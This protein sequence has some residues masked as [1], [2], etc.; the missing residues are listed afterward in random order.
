MHCSPVSLQ[1]LPDGAA[2]VGEIQLSLISNVKY[3]A[4]FMIHPYICGASVRSSWPLTAIASGRMPLAQV[5]FIQ[6]F[7]DEVFIV[8]SILP[9]IFSLC[10]CRPGTHPSKDPRS[11][12]VLVSRVWNPAFLSVP[13]PLHSNTGHVQC[14]TNPSCNT[15]PLLQIYGIPV[16]NYTVY[17]IHAFSVHWALLNIQTLRNTNLM[18]FL[19]S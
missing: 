17:C 8:F 5:L 2:P 18:S 3:T 12:S 4:H 11:S 16:R 6:I 10:V 9:L 13:E 14:R 1:N 15:F 19:A 7:R